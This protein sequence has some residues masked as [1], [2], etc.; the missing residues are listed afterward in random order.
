MTEISSSVMQTA[1]VIRENALEEKSIKERFEIGLAN[2]NNRK[3]RNGFQN[4]NGKNGSD[5][6]LVIPPPSSYAVTKSFESISTTAILKLRPKHIKIVQLYMTG[7]FKRTEIAD[8]VGVSDP[9]ITNVLKSPAAVDIMVENY[10]NVKE[11][12]NQLSNLAVSALR[13]GLTSKLEEQRVKAAIDYFKL[14]N[15]QIKKKVEVTGKDGGPIQVEDIKSK[16][17]AK[18]GLDPT[19]LIDM[20]EDNGS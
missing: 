20:E 5:N 1:T 2:L 14:I 18:L 8:I 17:F 11:D 16:M 4:G 13:D 3:T 15:T 12:F 10:G 19:I 7:K 9:T 6:R